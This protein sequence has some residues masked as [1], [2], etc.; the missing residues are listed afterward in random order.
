MCVGCALCVCGCALIVS[1]VSFHGNIK[2]IIEQVKKAALLRNVRRVASVLR[3]LQ[4]PNLSRT[5]N[6]QPLRCHL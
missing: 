5:Q 2:I 3:P 6:S 1:S 4:R